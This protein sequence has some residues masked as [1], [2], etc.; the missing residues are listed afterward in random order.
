MG[1]TGE[2]GHHPCL[3]PRMESPMAQSYDLSR[4]LSPLVQNTTLVAV[5]KLS[6]SSWLI[7]GVV[8]GVT[9]QP[10]KKLGPD[11]A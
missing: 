1:A 7:A 8:P 2:G 6:L 10:L 9:R 11:E 3:N 4:C 5:M